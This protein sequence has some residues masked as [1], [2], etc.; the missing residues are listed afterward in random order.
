MFKEAFAGMHGNIGVAPA[1]GGFQ[2]SPVHLEAADH[3][4]MTG[5]ADF[6]ASISQTPN[7]SNPMR[8][9]EQDSFAYQVSQETSLGGRSQ[10]DRS[11][12][13]QQKSQLRASYHSASVP[14]SALRLD[15]GVHSQNYK[16]H[17]IDDAA[18][19]TVSLGYKDGLLVKATLQQSSMQSAR[20]LEYTMGKLTSDTTT[21]GRQ[22]IERDV[23][24]ALSPH[25]QSEGGLSDEKRRDQRMQLLASLS[26]QVLLQAYPNGVSLG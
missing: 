17:E 10:A 1:P 4:A 11:I 19:S 26:G 25:E 21:P 13:Q 22:Q 12:S 3:A 9:A 5:L 6:S 24:R 20:A 8:P 23:L 18:S 2:A 7:A 16:Y 14:G 15:H